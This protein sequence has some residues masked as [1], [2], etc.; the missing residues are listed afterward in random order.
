MLRLKFTFET[1]APFMAG[2]DKTLETRQRLVETAGE[3][4]AKHGFRDA[5]I[6]EICQKAK[7]NIAAV[8][9]HFGGKEEIYAA[10]FDFARSCAVAQVDRQVPSIVPAEEQLRVFVYSMLTR[11][12][13]EGRP[14]LLGKLV[15]QEMIDPTKA[16]DS[17][18]NGQIRPN[19]ERLKAIVR[20]LIGTKVDDQ[21]L[22][23]C[24]FSI[25]AQWL[26]YFHCG[27]VVKRL[28]PDQRFGLQEI[29]HLADHITKFSVAALKGWKSR[30]SSPRRRI[31]PEHTL[32]KP[33]TE[34]ENENGTRNQRSHRTRAVELAGRDRR[35]ASLR[36]ARLSRRQD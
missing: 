3:V 24:A 8:H 21:E 22:W 6:R 1:I 34:T 23:L 18:V 5:T 12:F 2:K 11:F 19:S 16:L 35:P 25:A 20:E 26:F 31:L 7:A 28:N 33:S 27:P 30:T 9:Y 14:A 13:N 36:R 32:S 10:V 17:L 4:F 29:E 15:A